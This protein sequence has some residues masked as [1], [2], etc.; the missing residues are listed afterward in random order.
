MTS[1]IAIIDNYD[2]F[3]H[4]LVH[5]VKEINYESPVV[6]KNDDINYNIIDNCS[7]I[8]LSPGPGLPFES[9]ELMSFLNLYHKTHKI[10]G[11]CLG[12][13]AI[14][15]YFGGQLTQLDEVHHGVDCAMLHFND[16]PIY[17]H[18]P[19]NFVAGKYHS[20]IA[21]KENCPECLNVNCI[22]DE[23]RIMGINHKNFSVYAV[24]FHPES[25]MTPHGPEMMRN[26][27]NL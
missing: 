25:F 1:T 21:D 22:D 14:Y 3:T 19:N 6:F 23:G 18:I 5:L 17:E 4:N 20:W 11:V 16:C 15:E 9:G 2:S 10:L 27:L 26:F 24:Q 13:Q 7:H 8:I 12:L